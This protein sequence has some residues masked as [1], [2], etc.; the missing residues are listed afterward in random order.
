MDMS[1]TRATVPSGRRVAGPSPACSRATCAADADESCVPQMRHFVLHCVRRLGVP[2][3]VCDTVCLVVS[4]LVTNAVLHSGSRSVTVLVRIGPGDVLV[5]VRDSGQWCERSEPRQS[6]ADGGV[7][8]GRGLDLVRA[9]AD[10]CTID[11][12]PGGTVAAAGVR[13]EDVTSAPAGAV[14]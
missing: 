5:A 13:F 12:G 6:T 10:F 7:P 8:F 3:S 4:E 14:R 2:E 9:A 11:S 1:S